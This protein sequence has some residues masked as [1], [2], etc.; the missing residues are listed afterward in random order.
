MKSNCCKADVR[1]EGDTTKYYVCNECGKS[2]DLEANYFDLTGKEREKII[3]NSAKQANK[4]QRELVNKYM[5]KE[6]LLKLIEEGDGC[7]NDSGKYFIDMRRPTKFKN[8]CGY[9]G[10]PKDSLL[11]G[12]DYCYFDNENSLTNIQ[13]DIMNLKVHGGV[14]FS[15][16]LSEYKEKYWFFGFDCAHC[17]DLTLLSFDL[18]GFNLDKDFE[19]R[20][21]KY[22]QGECIKLMFQLE[23][24]EKKYSKK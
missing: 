23:K 1:V 20:D 21:K 8:W 10:V 12:L 3:N 15:G 7:I 9:V 17:D 5:T 6:E 14:T 24:I 22:V 13:K 2:C 4:E 11:Y 19:Y 18:S 16:H